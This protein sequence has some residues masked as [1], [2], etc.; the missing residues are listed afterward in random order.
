[1]A[2]A[3]FTYGEEASYAHV[4]CTTSS[5]EDQIAASME[6]VFDSDHT[7]VVFTSNVSD[8]ITYTAAA[9]TFTFSRAGI[10]H[11]VLTLVT[12]Q[13]DAGDGLH[14]TQFK[15]D[16]AVVYAGLIQVGEDE[17]PYESTHQ[18]IISVAAGEV[19]HVITKTSAQTAGIVKGTSIVI[20]EIT[21]GVYAS[22]TVST[23]GTN[24]TVA[25]F[26]PYA[27]TFS[28][29][30][31][32]PAYAT[33]YKI[34]SGVTFDAADGEWTV[35][36]AGKYLIM[37]NNVYRA[38][39]ATNTNITMKLYEGTNVLHTSAVKLH[40]TL[41]SR[42][43]TICVIEDLAANEKLEVSWDLGGSTGQ[44]RA[45]Q[46]GATF[47]VI[48]LQEGSAGP[49]AVAAGR[50]PGGYG[51]L[52]ACVVNKVALA[53]TAAEVNPFDE[54]TTAGGAGS[55]DFDTRASNG[56]AFSQ[57]DGT[58]TVS[59]DGLYFVMHN[60][61]STTTG[62]SN[63]TFKILVNG[64]AQVTMDSIYIDTL[65]DPMNNTNSGFLELQRD[66]VVTVTIDAAA[67]VNLTH[68]VGSTLTILRYYGFFSSF[69][70]TEAD[71]LISNDYTINTFSQDN[72]SAQYDRNID[73]VPFKMGI[74]G[75]G[76]LRGRCTQPSVVKLGDKKN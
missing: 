15:I 38:G 25:E 17:E 64:V 22:S 59:E 30:G 71:G 58:F 4:L 73:Q 5:D 19:L 8:D 54:D 9:G 2:N 47:T 52:Y 24:D 46:K 35:P 67:A 45:A 44:V 33:A 11:V 61:Y 56:I 28:G 37:V 65:P 39:G 26:N 50:G 51:D 62:D 16:S 43:S 7:N 13:V 68:G 12:S 41:Y 31:D 63:V 70:T 18:R 40:S 66:D 14:T 20:T 57:S 21:S 42:E 1:M 34:A 3:C 29:T 75:P 76:T 72:L 27:T 10:Y 60:S 6:P 36:S 32:G 49:G 69:D 55:A 23:A 53:A 74:R 48:K